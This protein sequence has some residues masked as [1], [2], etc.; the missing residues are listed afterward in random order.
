MEFSEAWALSAPEF[1]SE[2]A[3]FAAYRQA[4]DAA[5]VKPL[6]KTRWRRL[7]HPDDVVCAGCGTRTQLPA[8][9]WVANWC[10]RCLDD[11]DPGPFEQVAVIV[12]ETDREPTG[13]ILANGRGSCGRG[14]RRFRNRIVRR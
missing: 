5:G 3:A 2:A 4:C 12:A 6:G 14:R 10:A 7:P 9:G 1:K 11:G 8:P 13:D